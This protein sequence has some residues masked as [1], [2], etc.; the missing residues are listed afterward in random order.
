MG[1][2]ALVDLTYTRH[3]SICVNIITLLLLAGFGQ[4]FAQDNRQI[5]TQDD[6]L[7][8]SQDSRIAID[9]AANRYIQATDIYPTLFYG[10]D[11]KGYP[12]SKNHPYLNDVMYTKGRLSYQHVTYPE[13]FLRLD[14]NRDELMVKT[15]DFRNVVLNPDQVESVEMFG[16][17]I[18]YF[19]KDSLPGCPEAGYYFQLYNGICKVLEKRNAIMI[20][21]TEPGRLIRF[22]EF[23]TSYYL[24]KDGV[25]HT[26]KGKRGLWKAL[27]PYKTELK[28]TIASQRLNY[29][30]N[31]EEFLILTVHEYE[32]LSG[33]Q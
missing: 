24:Y 20:E 22:F 6:K 2:L 4:L 16:K 14:L 29:K 26:I 32:K 12:A 1:K 25:Y 17:H 21:N 23:S 3:V 9:S 18:F 13:V 31:T 11:Y 33:T 19:Q 27:S 10:L 8:F 15:P 7:T 5:T 28:R 30:K